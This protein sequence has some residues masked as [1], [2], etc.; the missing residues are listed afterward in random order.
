V[1]HLLSVLAYPAP[2]TKEGVRE[3][4]EAVGDEFAASSIVGS[5]DEQEVFFR[6]PASLVAIFGRT[7]ARFYAEN[8]A[9]APDI[10]D[11]HGEPLPEEEPDAVAEDIRHFVAVRL[12][13]VADEAVEPKAGDIAAPWSQDEDDNRAARFVGTLLERGLL[14]LISSRSRAQV[15][16]RV[17]QAL[18]NGVADPTR[19]ADIIIESSGVGEL[20]ADGEE[21]AEALAAAGRTEKRSR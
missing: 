11:E 1:R 9:G 14:E 20:Y 8:F 5:D 12:G 7:E 13:M 3:L 2:L 6:V 19:L 21:L 16:G 15:E 17:S 4:A 18:S 10:D